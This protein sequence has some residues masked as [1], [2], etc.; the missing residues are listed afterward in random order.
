MKA[1]KERFEITQADY[2]QMLKE[3]ADPEYALKPGKYTAQ[4]GRFAK[5]YP[6]LKKDD[7]EQH[8]QTAIYLDTDI[9]EFFKQHSKNSESM[10]YQA[11]INNLL[12]HYIE[13]E[14]SAKKSKRRRQQDDFRKLLS[15]TAFIKAVA[16]RV[17]KVL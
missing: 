16:E 10:A 12:R 17:R 5:K 13:N 7:V 6:D 14:R 1:N 8:P 2:E 11:E 3:G 15:D 9:V 4:R